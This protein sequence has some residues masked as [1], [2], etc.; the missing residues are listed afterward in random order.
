MADTC[1]TVSSQESRHHQ[2]ALSSLP[3]QRGKVRGQITGGEIANRSG[4]QDASCGHR[5]RDRAEEHW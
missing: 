2:E 3:G 4:R 1:V 5:P